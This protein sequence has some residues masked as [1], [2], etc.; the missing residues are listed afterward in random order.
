MG[1]IW[2]FSLVVADLPWFGRGASA[3]GRAAGGVK[4]HSLLFSAAEH[5]MDITLF[6]CTAKAG[7]YR[8]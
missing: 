5:H 1:G 2:C 8:S 3:R 4:K 7:N 6:Y